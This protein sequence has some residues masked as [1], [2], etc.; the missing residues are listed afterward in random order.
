[1]LISHDCIKLCEIFGSVS[2]KVNLSNDA[3]IKVKDDYSG[4]DYDVRYISSTLARRDW[5]Q[6]KQ[7][8]VDALN[9]KGGYKDQ[10]LAEGKKL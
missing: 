3:V 6:R 9:S 1:M 10:L 4:V 8:V 7:N 2:S 5:Q